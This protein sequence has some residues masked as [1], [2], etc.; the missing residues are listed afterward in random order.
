MKKINILL[1]LSVGL[2]LVIYSSQV[3][4]F[5]Y[6]ADQY[7]P[8]QTGSKN[9]IDGLESDEKKVDPFFPD[10]G[11]VEGK[12]FEEKLGEKTGD[13]TYIPYDNETVID[14]TEEVKAAKKETGQVVPG[15]LDDREQYL[16]TSNKELRRSFGR[17]GNGLFSFGYYRD[18]FDYDDSRNLFKK[19]FEESSGSHRYGMLMFTFDKYISRSL[20]SID[21]L[22]GINFG[23]GYNTGKGYFA[24]TGQQSNTQFG[25]WTIPIDVSLTAGIHLLSFLRFDLSAGPSVMG[26][27]QTRDD[28]E[29]AEKG[30]R[31][32]QVSWGYFGEGKL[33]IA[34]SDIFGK[35][36][37]RLYS[38]YSITNFYLDLK[39]RYQNYSNFQDNITISGISFGIALSFEYF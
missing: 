8:N 15:T 20:K 34:L 28:R 7:L 3:V 23:M 10:L 30:K 19:I 29:S 6:D 21:F 13:N 2:L 26:L 9:Y 39:G 33:K 31:R 16:A 32:R 24:Q 12:K 11:E 5:A 4:V 36:S 37:F 18:T 38:D 1:S 17:A 25:L 27:M 22:M 35:S 14:K